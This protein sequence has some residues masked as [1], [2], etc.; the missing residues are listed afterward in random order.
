M[1]NK[2]VCLF[3][4]PLFTSSGYGALSMA[5]AKSLLRRDSYELAIAPQRWGSCT[6]RYQTDDIINDEEKILASK[7]LKSPLSRSPEI[8][9]QVSIPSECT[10]IAKYNIICTAGIETNLPSPQFLEGANKAN[11]LIVTSQHNYNIFTAASFIKNYSDGRPPE[12]IKLTSPI[13]SIFWGCDTK[14]Y[15][16]IDADSIPVSI[17]T[18]FNE[19]IPTT[20]NF[21]FVG[22]WTH[23]GIF[24]DRKVIGNL[25]K[26]F[27]HTFRDTKN[28]PGL[29]V[30]TSGPTQS[31]VD[32]Y[33]MLGKLKEVTNIVKKESGSNDLPN[34][35]LLHGELSNEEMNGLYNHPK[36]KAMISFSRGEGANGPSLEFSM[37]GKPQLMPNW[38]AHLDFLNSEYANLLEGQLVH[39]PAESQNEWIIKDSSWFEVNLS[40]AQDIMK[41]MFHYYESFLDSSEKIRLENTTKFSMEAMDNR[42]GEILNKH[43]PVFAL[44]KKLVL[45]KLKK[46][47]LPTLNK[48]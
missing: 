19:K 15:K 9:F 24:N 29:I 40:K 41:Q 46:I 28:K 23:Q 11:L 20:F 21:L 7:I 25:I 37:T 2:P 10:P 33:E 45:P 18:L 4:A 5:L 34:V 1:N 26:T 27:L 17:N 43:V 48:Q 13:E 8:M 14:I 6:R 3:S 47:Q 12:E 38:S 16:K 22:M 42:L 36:V 35:Y 30:K 31:V 39:V 32:R 44:E